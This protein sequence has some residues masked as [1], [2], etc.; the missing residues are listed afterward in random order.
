MSQIKVASRYAQALFDIAKERNSLD[1]VYNDFNYFSS[2]IRDNRELHLLLQSPIIPT[3]KKKAV[4]EEI[5]SSKV[6]QLSSAF[7]VLMTD[8]GR[9]NILHSIAVSYIKLYN[10]ANNNL[11]VEVFTATELTPEIKTSLVSKLENWTKKNVL[12]V[13]NINPELKAGILLKFDD[14][15]YDA[16]IKSQ[17]NL[18]KKNLLGIK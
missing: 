13:F 4:L 16:T 6:S 8:K 18:L 15:I 3:F 5:F 10:E 2:V 14:M 9:E 11:P 12:P 7:L 17:L 1:V